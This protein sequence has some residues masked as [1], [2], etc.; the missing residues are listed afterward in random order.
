MSLNNGLICLLVLMTLYSTLGFEKHFSGLLRREATKT[1]LAN[2]D[3]SCSS[4]C[5]HACGHVRIHLIVR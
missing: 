3:N 5:A 2:K 4:L 1:M